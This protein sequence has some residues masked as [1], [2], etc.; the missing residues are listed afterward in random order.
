M[1]EDVLAVQDIDFSNLSDFGVSMSDTNNAVLPVETMLA[2]KEIVWPDLSAY[3][4]TLGVITVDGDKRQLIYADESGKYNH[5]ARNMGFSRTKWAGLWVRT[6][7]RVEASAF[8]TAFPKVVVKRRTEAE[9]SD[10]ALEKIRQLVEISRQTLL[11][12]FDALGPIDSASQPESRPAPVVKGLANK[13]D[14]ASKE[15]LDS[16]DIDLSPLIAEAR[17]LGTNMAGEEV[18]EAPDGARFVRFSVEGENSTND[19][20]VREMNRISADDLTAARFLRADSDAAMALCAQA[21]VKRMADGHVARVDE[22]H[23]F[24]RAVTSREFTQD[25]PELTRVV[26]AIDAARVGF[27]S[28]TAAEDA[29]EAEVKVADAAMFKKALLLHENAQYYTAIKSDR[30]TPLPIGVVF[31]HIA[32]AMPKGSSV[33]I[34]NALAGEFGGLE[35]S[36]GGVS[37]FRTANVD[38]VQDILLGAYSGKP[39]EQ[40]VQAYG[41]AVTRED[42]AKVLTSLERMRMN[43][44]GVFVIEGDAVPG[45]IGPSS[46]RFLDSLANMREIEGI[47]DVDGSLMGVPG[48]LPSRIVVVGSGRE[49]PGHGG[50]PSTV[51]YVTDYASLWTWGAK[52]TEAIRK[53]GSVPYIER[54][55]VSNQAVIESQF[56]TPYI[57]TSMI[58]EP[59]LMI[60]R[61][62]ASPVRRAMLSV[63]K[64]TPHL[65]SWLQNKLEYPDGPAMAEALSAEQADAIALGMHRTQSGLGFIVGD[66]TGIG[67]GR[68]IAGLARAARAKGEPV[69]FLTEKAELFTDLWRDIEDTN[70]EAFFKN[71]FILNE[72]AEIVST[73]TGEVVAKSAAREDVEKTLRSMKFPEGADIVFATY[74]QFNRDPVK[75]IQSAGKINLDAHTKSQLSQS[76][77]NLM[78]WVAQK[79]R[80]EGKKDLTPVIVESV[81]ILANQDLID[82]MPMTALKSLWIGKATEGTTLIMDESH[83]ASGE[84]SQTNL[85]LTKGV[86]AAKDVYYSSAT[87]ARGEKNMRIY[88]RLFP[89]SVDVE[90]LHETLSKGGEPLQEA[91]SSMLAED[92]ALIR[93]EHDL[94]ML[95][96]EPKA[97][98]KRT[99]RNEKYAD[100]LAEILSAM[101]LLSREGRL[102]G[103]SLSKETRDAFVKANLGQPG[104]TA[105]SVLDRAAD[106]GVVKRSNI[107]N[108]LYMIMRSF[109]AIMTCELA[110]EEAVNALKEGR[111]PVLVIDHTMESE[112]NKRIEESMGKGDGKETPDG[113]LMKTPGYR[114]ILLARLDALLKV[115][116]DGKDLG[117]RAI[118]QY[119]GVIAQIEKLIAAFPDLPTS[120]L[121]LVREGIER[122]GYN[123]AEIS[124]RKKRVKFVKGGVLIEPINKKERKTAKE[125]F[126]NGDAHA[127]ILTRAGNAGISLHDSNRF[128][129]RGQRELIEVEVPEDVVA[130]TQFFGRVNRKGQVSYP[131]IKTLSTNLPAQ[132]RV[133]AL[134]NNKLRRM[135]ANI[136]A[137]RDNAA[138]TKDVADIL[139]SVGNEVAYRFLQLDPDLAQKLDIDIDA[140]TSTYDEDEDKQ[141]VN[142]GGDK[143]IS[144]LMNRLVLLPIV[145][146]RAIIESITL[147]FNALIEELDAKGENPLK[148]RFYDVNAV[149]T[150]TEML[151]LA[152]ASV[153]TA[154]NTRISAFDRGVN[155]TYIKYT[156]HHEAMP[157]RELIKIMKDYRGQMDGHIDK[158]YGDLQEYQ[159]W[160]KAN[161]KGEFQDFLVKSLI[162]NKDTL[163]TKF[164][165]KDSLTIVHALALNDN[166]MVKQ[167]NQKISDMVVALSTLKLGSR[168]TSHDSWSGTTS[169][170]SIV[171]AVIP[172]DPEYMHH[173][174]R[175]R[176]RYAV[177]GR[178]SIQ[179]MSLSALMNEATF[180]VSDTEFN[181]DILK[182]FDETKACS[183][184][185]NRPLMDGNLFRASEMSIQTGM[186]SQA[187][188]TDVNG[189]TNRAIF[190]PTFFNPKNFNKLP[191]RI[192]DKSLAL[193]FFN[194]VSTGQLH[195]SSGA[196]KHLAETTKIVKRGITISK[197]VTECTVSV[198]GSRAWIS[199]LKNNPD[200]MK[201][202]GPFGGSRSKL[203]ATFSVNDLAQ[204][205]DA[206]YA[207]GMTMYAH[208]DD[209]YDKL[210]MKRGQVYSQMSPYS[211]AQA[212]SSHSVRTW[213]AERFGVDAATAASTKELTDKKALKEKGD[214]KNAGT[215][216]KA[217]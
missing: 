35:S 103:D 192:H 139:N 170:N 114:S 194:D 116:L 30:M 149:T 176:V 120:P 80:S 117:L 40:A 88:R 57:P 100:Q 190:M 10:A 200:L 69:L 206:V 183:Y 186:G 91:L 42:H 191:L 199:W 138:I 92:G 167:V 16:E 121:D 110:V 135:S 201:V 48:A 73:K 145:Q 210:N 86:M 78:N 165:N 153:N 19:R 62:L 7:T 56:Q 41:T 182:V 178:M 193:D 179:E 207:T 136:T 106:V 160:L 174:G 128:I 143:F 43:G 113:Y 38:E 24:F 140:V 130:R 26:R 46:R 60:P 211:K 31:Q 150:K 146:Q 67:K 98:K 13:G 216:L 171:V 164:L 22:L 214:A 107:G 123:V 85:N 61:N 95:K 96:F 118:P 172:P 53:P 188:Y 204:M 161:P 147:E 212:T 105:Q 75:A 148:S 72:G 29:T 184:E 101:T 74:S 65:D 15:V 177:P 125:R 195:S 203:Y 47:V 5:I 9:I 20:I 51:P 185:V 181:P 71:I 205:V 84:S 94:S 137:N 198:P 58:S 44:L 23:R 196:T 59:S 159:A 169:D 87:F 64:E 36:A 152:S 119:A 97:D 112:L 25:D 68:I 49:I 141:V 124:G 162:E 202:T 18:L 77:K 1:L 33:R 45:R 208:A 70:S 34:D 155:V 89:S 93:R 154:T 108:S 54:G 158:K 63:L 17:L 82:A 27:V 217:A 213:F 175:Y 76:A 8:R 90:A 126:N 142:L 163:L 133:L 52:I 173:A 11:P 187:D 28:A 134:Q 109:L 55:G 151:E 102:L 37:A 111:K 3:G 122:A 4:I 12:G 81:D 166:N 99:A 115:S 66:Q 39:L 197:G 104:L 2:P 131:V 189:M 21:F 32:S 83:N 180:K 209:H 168:I 14:A 132:N 50:L 129:N 79:R 6:D 156:Q 215:L 144:E 127:I 157:G